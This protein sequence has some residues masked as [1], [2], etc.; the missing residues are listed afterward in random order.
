MKE[1]PE[2]DIRT[3]RRAPSWK[4]LAT[5]AAILAVIQACLTIRGMGIE[6]FVL[7]VLILFVGYWLFFT[8]LFWLWGRFRDRA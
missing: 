4:L 3:Q 2:N 7:W 8:L 5:A 6:G 1:K